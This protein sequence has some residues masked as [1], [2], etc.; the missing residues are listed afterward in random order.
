MIT[1]DQ[2]QT[3]VAETFD[4]IDGVAS[5]DNIMATLT[6]VAPPELINLLGTL[7]ALA[8]RVHMLSAEVAGAITATVAEAAG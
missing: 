1:F 5:E 2:L 7:S 3:A 4:H 8:M 6:E